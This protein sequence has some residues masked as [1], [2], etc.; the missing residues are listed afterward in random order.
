MK[1]VSIVIPIY[2]AEK[3]LINCINSILN[4]TYKNIEILLV[5]DGSNDG[6][7]KI[8]E[9]YQEKDEGILGPF[10]WRTTEVS[11]ARNFGMDMAT[12]DYII[13]V[14]ADDTIDPDTVGDNVKLA[15]ENNVELVLFCFRYLL[16][17][18]RH[19]KENEL[20]LIFCRNFR[21]VF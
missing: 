14:D 10:F 16:T 6:S 8:C 15:E 11:T 9:Q 5:D 18:E 19:I 21:C 12:G 17:E 3:Y 20:K 2:N 7:K 1:K 13:F 4:Q